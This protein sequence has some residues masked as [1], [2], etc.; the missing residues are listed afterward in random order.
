[1]RDA[2]P[3]LA[4]PVPN[5]SGAVGFVAHNPR[6]TDPWAASASTFGRVPPH[7]LLK[8]PALVLLA[9]LKDKAHRL[10]GSFGADIQLG[11]EAALLPPELFGL[12]V[13]FFAPATCWWA[14]T[15][16]LST[17]WMFQSN[18]PYIRATICYG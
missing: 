4:Q 13:L 7:A 15:M 3:V 17:K 9:R 10:A 14:R 1:N 18:I 5:A 2:D 16:V 11:R 6:R 8:R 12:R